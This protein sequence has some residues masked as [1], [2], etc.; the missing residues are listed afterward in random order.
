VADIILHHYP[1]SPFAE[2]IRLILGYKGLNYRSVTIPMIMPKPNLL[3]LTGGYRKTP[4]MQ[5][6][7]D[8]YCD[9]E[10]IARVINQLHPEKPL[11]PKGQEA[12]AGTMA[13]WSDSVLFSLAISVVFQ[14][15]AM[16]ANAVFRD[17]E[18]AAAFAADRAEL[19]KGGSQIAQPF[20]IANGQ[21]LAHMKRL[22]NQL[23]DGRSFLLGDDP[24]IADF[25][26]YHCIWLIHN[27]EAIREVL[28]P[29]EKLLAWRQ[30]M[31]SFGN[32]NPS[33]LSGEEAL[34]IARASEPTNVERRSALNPDALALGETVE[35]LPTDYGLDP[36]KG[37]LLVS[38]LEEIAIAR[39]DQRTGDLVVHFPR[40]GF[41]VRKC[42]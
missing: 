21:F 2:K 41:Q 3:P 27:V 31:E 13:Q 34:D 11:Y 6:G 22:D 15:K 10:I 30:R 16:A 39:T 26:T 14:P 29:F 8:I 18:T 37:T 4:V 12:S 23:A 32:G 40:M 24:S 42:E 35:V 36:V 28:T 7:A 1:E 20:E 5:I 17:Q 38:S 25:S 33:Q 19:V 9:T